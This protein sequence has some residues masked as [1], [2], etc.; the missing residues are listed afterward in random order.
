MYK[1]LGVIII[2][3]V[4]IFQAKAKNLK[5]DPLAPTPILKR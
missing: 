5:S 1:A 4:V 3:S 2:F